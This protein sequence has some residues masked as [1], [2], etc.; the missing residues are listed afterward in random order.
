MRTS[1]NYINF[2]DGIL[3]LHKLSNYGGCVV[4]L[5]DMCGMFGLLCFG[6]VFLILLVYFSVVVKNERK[7]RHVPHSSFSED[8]YSGPLKCK[9]TFDKNKGHDVNDGLRSL[10]HSVTHL[11]VIMDGNRRYGR[12]RYRQFENSTPIEEI[13]SFCKRISTEVSE[14]NNVIISDNTPH[15]SRTW[16]NDRY[17]K[18]SRLIKNTFFDGHRLGGEKL[19]EFVKDCIE[20]RIA[21]LTVYAF[22]TDNWNRPVVELNVLMTLFFLF[23]GKIR[24]TTYKYGIFI[25][26][27]STEP[28]KLPIHVL[29]MMESLECDSRLISPRRITVNICVSYSGQS[30]M[31]TAFNRIFQRRLSSGDTREISK[32]EISAEMLQSITQA[33]HEEEDKK[34]F[35]NSVPREPQL[36]L[37]T[38]GEQ[39]ISDFL[40]YECAYSE[41][42]FISK[43]WP[44][45]T[46]MDLK[47]ALL[48]YFKR[49]RRLGR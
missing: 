37:R 1:E 3:W 26:F 23:F 2:Q 42:E 31:V 46:R 4:L 41:F 17:T 29:K 28:G 27:V 19:I 11:A 47:E 30:E 15:L 35:T 32:D 39:R 9:M 34:V 22:S 24:S 14:V 6:I 36:I 12:E 33:N 7:H 38:S 8:S 48:K 25:R 13:Q 43:K 16:F 5:E 40:L 20:A 49:D 44:E 10:P 21:M 18:L 45:I